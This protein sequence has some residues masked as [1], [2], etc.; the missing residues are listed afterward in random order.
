[1]AT[2]I[3][4]INVFVHRLLIEGTVEATSGKKIGAL[5][6]VRSRNTPLSFEMECVSLIMPGL[7]VLNSLIN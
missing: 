4:Q 3:V 5:N 2:V 7:I 1:M 6:M